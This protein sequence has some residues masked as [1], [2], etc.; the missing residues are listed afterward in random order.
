M[1]EF[2]KKITAPVSRRVFIHGAGLAGAAAFL[3]ACAPGGGATTA[4]GATVTPTTA[5]GATPAP[6]PEPTPKT[7][8]GPLKFANWTAYI[9]L[10]GAAS[11]AGEY[12]PGSSPAIEAFKQKYGVEVDYEE[13]IDDNNSFIATIKPALVAGLATGWDLIVITDWMAAKVIASG[14]AEKLD[15]KNVPNCVANLRDPLKN[16]VWDP[17]N[18]YHYSWQSGMT[19]IGYNTTAYKEN[20]LADP[21]KL[22]DL[23]KVPPNKLTFLSESRDT[24]GL[25]LLK[26]GIKADPATVTDADLQKVYD[27]IKPLVD[28]GLR[29]TGNDYL[30]DFGQ[31]KVWA[32]MVWSG[33]L[34]SSA[35]EDDVFVFPEEGTMIWTDNMLI[36][37]GAA[38][39]YTAELMM[40]FVYEPEIA[41]SIA[42]WIYYVSPVKGIGDLIKEL[43]PGAEENPL[44]FPTDEIVAKQQNFQFLPEA[45]ESKMNELFA[46]LSGL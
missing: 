30:Q 1:N 2:E 25:A 16:Q 34:A 32:A 36:P 43:D 20:G 40:D 41:A 21:T 28:K 19:G 10:V 42:D 27:D 39:K 17:G 33:D 13:K 31:K 4:P 11:D 37:K 9:D 12:S 44:L 26:L 35:G 8:S 14:W 29:F 45:L 23:W 24:F 22:A 3:A 6:T 7:I 5:P 46:D 15:Q 38:N 18:D